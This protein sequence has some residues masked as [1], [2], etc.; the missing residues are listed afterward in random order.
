MH[1]HSG[2][3]RYITMLLKHLRL[4]AGNERQLVVFSPD[5]FV[6]GGFRYIGTRSR[7]LSLFEQIDLCK[8]KL[9]THLDLFHSPQFNIPLFSRVPQITTIHDCAY[10]RFPEEFSSIL[11]RC[12]YAFMFR[13][14]L[15]K[16]KKIIAVSHA[17]KGDLQEIYHVRAEKIRVIHEGVDD[18]FFESPVDARQVVTDIDGPFMLF[19]GIPRPR[20]NLENILRS[21]AATKGHI[22]CKT[23]LVIAGPTDNRFLNIRHLADT[24]NVDEKIVL[25]G[26]IT[27][28]K[29]RSLY[30][31]A[32]CFLFPTLY[33]G[34]GLPILEAM[35]S[36][37][38]VITS[39]RPA[40]VEIAGD[41]AL[42]VDPVDVG[43]MA[44]A[45]VRIS[46]DNSFR[47]G[48]IQ[49]GLDRARMFSWKTCA[50]QT[51]SIYT[52]VING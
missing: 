19:V 42:V 23:K 38:P 43:A 17:T 27:D 49:K 32:T 12:L 44:E 24:L 5:Q 50:E 20:K 30:R 41:A 25:T 9:G 1:A 16:S 51:L 28:Q 10:S 14:A 8:S 29:L 11:D 34:F 4:Q 15:V 48:L 36:G 46:E 39:Q 26:T 3:G 40:H 7:P 37:A 6:G 21:F 33:E 52:E 35:A 2:I 31:S 47:E 13:S 45:M 22:D 18:E